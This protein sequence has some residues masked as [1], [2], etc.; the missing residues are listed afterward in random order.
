VG[1]Y[2]TMHSRLDLYYYETEEYRSSLTSAYR[3]V[4]AIMDY[5]FRERIFENNHYRKVIN[6][7]VQGVKWNTRYLK[8]VIGSG[9]ET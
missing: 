3:G 2:I 7:R 9:M 4:E 1:S 8:P 6:D 5:N